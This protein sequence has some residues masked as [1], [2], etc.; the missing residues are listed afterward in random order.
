VLEVN[1]ACTLFH[2]DGRWL[3]LGSRVDGGT[4]ETPWVV[5]LTAGG[6]SIVAATLSPDS[7]RS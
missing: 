1:I 7:G 2:A 4:R 3:T 6:E 5:R